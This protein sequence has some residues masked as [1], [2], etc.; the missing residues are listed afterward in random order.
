MILLPYQS[1]TEMKL[2][3]EK[4]TAAAKS[5]IH[6]VIDM[7]GFSISIKN[8]KKVQINNDLPFSGL[9]LLHYTQALPL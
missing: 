1:K 2:I 9:T 5:R 4:R 6:V 7:P 8:L 3:L